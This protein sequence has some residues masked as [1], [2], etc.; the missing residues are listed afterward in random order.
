MAIRPNVRH[1]PRQE[2]HA[3]APASMKR[4]PPSDVVDAHA[5]AVT[6]LISPEDALCRRSR[7]LQHGHVIL[8]DLKALT[9]IVVRT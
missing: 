9:V 4:R 7:G 6:Q 1:P 3:D 8:Q 2:H 5:I